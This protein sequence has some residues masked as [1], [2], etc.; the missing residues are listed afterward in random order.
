MIPPQPP[1]PQ[2]TMSEQPA[3]SAKATG[4]VTTA[5]FGVVFAFVAIVLVAIFSDGDDKKNDDKPMRES[6][7]VMC[8]EFVKKRLKS[9]GS[10]KFPDPFDADYAQTKVL[11]DKKPWKYE[12][13]GVVDSQN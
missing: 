5:C 13:T 6:A 9:P 7:A 8:E 12:V 2:D 3:A 4:C 1:P 10:A 11:S